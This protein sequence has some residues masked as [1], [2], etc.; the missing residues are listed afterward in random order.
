MSNI[1]ASLNNVPGRVGQAARTA[2]QLVERMARLGYA[3]KGVIYIIVGIL[4]V[5]VAAHAGGRTTNTKGALAT[6]AHEPYGQFLLG[7]VAVGLAGYALWC[8]VQAAL[9]TENKGQDAKGIGKRLG[10]AGSGI[11][12]GFLSYLAFR[13]VI[14]AFQH[15]GSGGTGKSAQGWTAEVMAHPWGQWLVA[16]I[17][18]FIILLG[19]GR[20]VAS[21]HSKFQEKLK[22]EEMSQTQQ[23]AATFIG[24]WGASARGVVFVIV[25]ILLV[26][27]AV[28]VNPHKVVGLDGALATLA[29]QPYGSFLLAIVA[30]GLIAYGIYQLVQARYRR[31]VV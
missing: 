18:V 2:A 7:I 10:R 11:G 19:L 28:S 15:T 1:N 22:T 24:K 31:I 8:F 4:A 13:M 25:G 27:A 9:D 21:Y 23:Q 5:E 26:E 12:Y 17:G 14:A 29:H 16:L 20:L 30:L 6:I 3:A